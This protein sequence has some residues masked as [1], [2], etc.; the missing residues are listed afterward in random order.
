MDA[1]I[2]WSPEAADDL[3]LI[4]KYIARDSPRYARQ[5]AVDVLQTVE[6]AAQFPRSGRT[7]PEL[8]DPAVRELIVYSYRVI[9]RISGDAIHIAAI[10]HGA[11]DFGS[12]IQGREI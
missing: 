4:C 10:V 5:V 3:E 12:A 11:R 2:I 7:V 6:R 9:Y 8:N 1:R